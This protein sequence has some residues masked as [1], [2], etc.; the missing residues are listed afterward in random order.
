MEQ[1][2]DRQ[3]IYQDILDLPETWVGEIINGRLV[4]HPA[5]TGNRL[6]A[7]GQLG[8]V[9]SCHF[10]HVTSGGIDDD[11]RQD[12]TASSQSPLQRD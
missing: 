5:L 10:G 6:F 11:G 3:A 12:R 8:A 4:T 9:L 7:K 2:S 1:T